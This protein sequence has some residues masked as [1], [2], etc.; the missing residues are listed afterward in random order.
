[1]TDHGTG[2]HHGHHHGPVTAGSARA[3]LW[4]L[5]VTLLLM[6]I[7]AVG[8]WLTG[9]LALLA[10]AGHL[11]VD[12]GSLAVSLIG[13]WIAMRPATAQMSYG[14]RRAEMF[15]AVTNGLALWA[16]AAAIVYEAVR[17]LAAPHPIVAS[18]MLGIAVLGL[19]GNL[20]S[21]ALLAP[22]RG[23]SLNVRAALAHVLADAAAAVGTIA[24]SLVILTTG[25]TAA[26]PLV[27]LGIAG[28][29]IVMAWPIV[30]HAVEVLMEGTPRGV[31]IPE[32]DAAM[33]GVPGV[34]GI[35]DL[36]VWSVT[37]GVP[38]VTGHVLIADPAS[39]QRILVD[40]CALLHDR[41]HLGHVTLQME[42]EPLD[43]PW[44]PNCGPEVPVP[45][46]PAR[47]DGAFR[48]G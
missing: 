48:S 22:A 31:S 44:H 33:R 40:L 25:W 18:G 3:L 41:F 13:G 6:A 15:A 36:H 20:A 21:S 9:S 5:A 27:S 24:A 43:A 45:V 19:V 2:G 4:T 34:L 29:L 35:H 30:G 28:V 46:A 38:A 23:T 1:M 7:E 12:V 14:Y 8:G 16:I 10:D 17:R 11:L 26:D 32:V 37:S 39:A 42:T 47:G